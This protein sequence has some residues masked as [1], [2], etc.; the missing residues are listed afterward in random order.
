MRNKNP[1]R[2][3]VE[4]YFVLD[5][6]ALVFLLPNSK[7][8]H[9]G[10]ANPNNTTFV[11]QLPFKISAEKSNLTAKLSFDT[12]GIRIL[13]LDS[14]NNIFYSGNVKD[15]KFEFIIL[16]NVLKQSLHLSPTE[17]IST[18]YFRL[19][20][21]K[22]RKLV[23][24]YWKPSAEE[25]FNKNYT[26]Q[27]IATAKSNDANS[28]EL[29]DKT[30]FGLNIIFDA[31]IA[32]YDAANSMNQQQVFNIL[33]SIKRSEF[34][35]SNQNTGSFDLIPE[36]DYI[37]A[38]A[39]QKW[40][41]AINAY[42]IN[43]LKD[44]KSR[45]ELITN[46][47]SKNYNA[48]L[49]MDISTNKIIISG[50]TPANAKLNVTLKVT[51]KSDN[52][53]QSISFNVLPMPIQQPNIDKIM[54]PGKKYIIDP[55]LPL[56]EK[57]TKALLKIQNTIRARSTQGEI[58]QFTPDFSDTG[59]VFTL[60]RYIDNQLIGEDIK[61]RVISFPIP[62]IIE[63]QQI[64]SNEIKVKTRSYGYLVDESNLVNYFELSGNAQYR[65]LY[66]RIEEDKDKFIHLQTFIFTPKNNDNNFKFSIKAIDKLGK[67]S[68]SRTF[69]QD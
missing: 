13:S 26:V 8:K 39:Y 68:N 22:E 51:R 49:D 19:T 24:F 1:K 52:Q 25:K 21:N 10:G 65:E 56:T 11:S 64:K 7:E 47:Y 38:L 37:R 66:G 17:P 30:Q 42:N 23:S 69:N 20:E 18:K 40:S 29:Q 41:I 14:N 50:K 59:R 3:S 48:D 35:Q 32:N 27:V 61:I 31:T 57:E 28:L 60:E 33:D 55:K 67:K 34:L 12:N 45:P 62:E 54:Y 46:L 2:K 6:A 53:E 63:I 44:L 58:F 15:V 36:K 4:I 16:D 43:L 9:N 5:L